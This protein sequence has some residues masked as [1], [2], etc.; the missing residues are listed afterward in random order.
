V[1]EILAN[2]RYTGRQ[3]WNRQRTDFDPVDPA[4]TTRFHRRAG[5]DRAA[6]PGRA[7]R[8]LLAVGRA[9]VLWP[10]RDVRAG[11]AAV[12][13]AVSLGAAGRAAAGRA[14]VRLHVRGQPGAGRAAVIGQGLVARLVAQVT[15]RQ[16]TP[17]DHGHAEP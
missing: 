6:R 2:P 16:T 10:G 5:L 7:R 12:T 8:G 13:G 15:D 17:N 4:N 9:G 3:V 14:P 1:A 11:I